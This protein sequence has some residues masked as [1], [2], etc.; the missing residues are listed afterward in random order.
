[1]SAV[2]LGVF[3]DY[4]GAD[5]ARL[6]LFA[7]G[8]PTD[9]VDLTAGCDPGQ[10]RL[11]PAE[12]L[13]DKFELY[14]GTLFRLAHE[15]GLAESLARRVDSGAA[16]VTVHPRGVIETMRAIAILKG[17]GAEELAE[18]HL[19]HHALEHAAAV[20]RKPWVSYLWPEMTGDYHCIYCRLFGRHDH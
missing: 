1:M 16:T 15:R 13:H 5:H 3:S 14:F 20:H 2:L 19:N 11:V 7:D 4:P 9:R 12:A 17:A 6:T 8:F 18:H 10:A